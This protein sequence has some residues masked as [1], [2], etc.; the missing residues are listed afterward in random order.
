MPRGAA[1]QSGKPNPLH[2]YGFYSKRDKRRRQSLVAKFALHT[3]YD[4]GANHSI[5]GSRRCIFVQAL[6]EWKL[7][8][9]LDQCDVMSFPK[10]SSPS[11]SFSTSQLRVTALPSQYLCSSRC[12]EKWRLN[13]KHETFI[14]CFHYQPTLSQ[15]IRENK[16]FSLSSRRFSSRHLARKHL[17]V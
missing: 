11:P 17:L 6:S 3:K 14:L 4:N 7:G 13:V 9:V 8:R 12:G 15:P 10:W 5:K 1:K 2:K 16:I